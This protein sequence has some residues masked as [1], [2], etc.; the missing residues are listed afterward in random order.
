[1]HSYQTI[2]AP[3]LSPGLLSKKFKIML[4]NICP[5]CNVAYGET[6]VKSYYVSTSS[7]EDVYSFFF[8]PHCQECFI[9]K[10]PA[11]DKCSD[12]TPLCAINSTFPNFLHGTNFS[13]QLKTLSPQFVKIYHESEQ[14]ENINLIKICGMGYRK[15]LEFLIKDYAIYNKPDCKE[16]IEKSPLGKCIDT[17]I[18]NPQIKTLAKASTWLGNDEAH[19]I[20]KHEHYNI[21]DLKRFISAT[22]AYIVFEFSYVEA[23]SFLNAPQ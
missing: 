15:A 13:E 23:V 17:Y 21:S 9:T 8:C 20:R 14:A 6:P 7:S 5:I 2:K 11:A 18:E 16:E 3:S 12:G 22:V 1:M 19:Y 4:P 10:S